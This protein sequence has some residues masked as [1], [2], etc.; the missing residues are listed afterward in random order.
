MMAKDALYS[1]TR[2][3]RTFVDL[4]HTANVMLEKAEKDERGSYHTILTSILFLAFTFE[5]YLNH[6][7]EQHLRIWGEDERLKVREKYDRIC[8]ALVVTPDSSR[9]PYQVIDTL[10]KFRNG[11][12]HG[13][14]VE[15][16]ESKKISRDDNP[17]AHAPKTFIEEHCTIKNAH[18]FMEDLDTIV[19]E[20]NVAAGMDDYPYVNGTTISTLKLDANAT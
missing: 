12:A 18:R 2:Q 19:T 5:A 16:T 20:L 1:G 14:S 10:F 6:L 9:R 7:G 17:S 8:E 4:R 11:L 3:V 15:L 13:R